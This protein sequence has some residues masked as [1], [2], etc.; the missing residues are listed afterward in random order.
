MKS[1]MKLEL[2]RLVV[3]SFDTGEG[4]RIRGTVRGHGTFACTDHCTGDGGA[5]CDGAVSCGMEYTCDRAELTC[6]MSCGACTT[7]RCGGDG[8]LSTGCQSGMST[9]LCSQPCW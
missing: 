7:E 2:D 5:T 1:K 4:T 3:E 9:C 8:G 6:G